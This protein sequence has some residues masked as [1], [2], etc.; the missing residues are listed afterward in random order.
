MRK[1]EQEFDSKS[2][3]SKDL[4]PLKHGRDYHRL[5]RGETLRFENQSNFNGFCQY[6]H[7]NDFWLRLSPAKAE[8]ISTVPFE[9]FIFHDILSDEEIEFLQK[10][11]IDLLQP[12]G[13]HHIREGNINI[14]KLSPER[15]QS[16]AWMF[17]Y[18]YPEL[19]PISNRLHRIL[20]LNIHNQEEYP[21]TSEGYQVII[22]SFIVS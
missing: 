5:C 1:R 18:E 16:S 19:E 9:L 22:R 8:I 10:V 15:T 7:Q 3:S 21:G 13:V 12:S 20:N 14:L 6:W 2:F 17:D 4:E 11:G